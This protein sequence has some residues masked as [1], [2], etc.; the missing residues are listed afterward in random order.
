[1]TTRLLAA[2]SAGCATSCCLLFM[3]QHFPLFTCQSCPFLNRTTAVDAPST[4]P[5]F[6]FIWVR[7]PLVFRG[8]PRTSTF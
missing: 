1:M 4:F 7:F 6:F 2:A 8:S 3:S 5:L